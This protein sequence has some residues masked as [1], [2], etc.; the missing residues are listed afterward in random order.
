M[1]FQ[2][3][4]AASMKITAFWYNLVEVDRLFRGSYSLHHQ[5]NKLAFIIVLMM[6]AVSTNGTSA[7]FYETARRRILGGI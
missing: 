1:K 4:T 6:E 7:N 2:V 5:G 3:L